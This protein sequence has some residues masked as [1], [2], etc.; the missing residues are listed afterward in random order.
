[1]R[2]VEIMTRMDEARSRRRQEAATFRWLGL[3]A[4]P[5]FALMALA[6]G[7]VHDGGTDILC[8]AAHAPW[9]IGGMAPMYLL[10]SVF[11]SAPWLKLAARLV[12]R[13]QST[14]YGGRRIACR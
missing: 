1:M 5:S 7:L 12:G 2:R 13:G 9:S 14:L 4:T 8:S 6:T 11:H 10:M 3:A